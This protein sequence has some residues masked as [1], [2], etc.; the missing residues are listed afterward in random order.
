MEAKRIARSLAA[1]ITR[2]PPQLHVL[3]D[4]LSAFAR[5]SQVLEGSIC[6]WFSNAD[7]CM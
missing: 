6:H 1:Y 2:Q 3:F 7:K 4:L 5:K